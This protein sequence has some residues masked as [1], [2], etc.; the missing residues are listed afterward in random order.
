MTGLVDIGTHFLYLRGAGPPRNPSIPAVICIVGMAD[1]SVSMMSLM[2]HISE[3]A[4]V[5]AYDRSGLGQSELPPNFTQADKSYVNIAK[6]LHTLLEKAHISPPYVLVMHSM[7]GLPGREFLH[8]WPEE[9]AGMVFVDCVTEENYK[10]R[11]KDLPGIMR[12]MQEGVD[13]SWLWTERKPVMTDA[14]LKAALDNEGL[15]EAPPATKVSKELNMQ[16]IFGEVANLISSSDVLA[17]KKQFETSPMG[18]KPVSVIKGDSPGEWR[19]QFERAVKAGKGTDE[20]RQLVSGYLESADMLQLW[21]Q[22]RQLRL[23]SNSRMVEAKNSWH[24]VH[25]YEPDLVVKEVKW[26]LDEYARMKSYH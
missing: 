15:G 5:H 6:E 18:D 12:S 24:N 16:A 8:L 17:A 19:G 13:Q 4:R 14:E 9:V 21:L 7:G 2:R 25:W 20:Q 11:P 23:S 1:T 22:F 10:H 3:H 26:C